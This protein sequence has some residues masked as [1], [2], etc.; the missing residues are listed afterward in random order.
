MQIKRRTIVGNNTNYTA[1]ESGLRRGERKYSDGLAARGK[2]NPDST[3]F[4]LKIRIHRE[5][6]TR[7]RTSFRTRDQ[8]F[9]KFSEIYE[10]KNRHCK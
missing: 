1:I 4:Q 6:Y 8:K 9:G 3:D 10:P 2:L 5:N 7:V